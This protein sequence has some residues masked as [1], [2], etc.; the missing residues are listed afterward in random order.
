MLSFMQDK[1][2]MLIWI[3][4]IYVCVSCEASYSDANYTIAF[5]VV[6]IIGLNTTYLIL[7]LDFSKNSIKERA[8]SRR[9]LRNLLWRA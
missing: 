9:G 7:D 2:H 4:S 8:M 3:P 1:F 5:H 6:R